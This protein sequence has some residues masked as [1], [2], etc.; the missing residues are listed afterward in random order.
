MAEQIEPP[1]PPT[2][3]YRCPGP[4]QRK[5]G[6]FGYMPTYSKAEWEAHLEK[7]WFKTLPEAIEHYDNP[8]PKKAAPKPKP[9]KVE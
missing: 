4:H 3:V 9:K 2:L 5:G 1:F 8:K 6:T 7:G